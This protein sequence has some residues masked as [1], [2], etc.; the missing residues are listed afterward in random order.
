MKT[1][2]TYRLTIQS[3]DDE[4]TATRLLRQALK[5]LLRT[6]GFRCLAVEDMTAKPARLKIESARQQGEHVGGAGDDAA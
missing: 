5:C 6:F 2:P 1:K 4:S 3:N